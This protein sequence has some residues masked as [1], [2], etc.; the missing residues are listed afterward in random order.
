V[1]L[2]IEVL[3]LFLLLLLTIVFYILLVR[4]EVFLF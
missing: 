2:I 3:F 4:T 1:S